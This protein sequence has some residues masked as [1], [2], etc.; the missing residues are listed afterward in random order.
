MWVI[1][2]LEVLLN[3]GLNQLLG[4]CL[5]LTNHG[6][7]PV[8]FQRI[9]GSTFG[10]LLLPGHKKSSW[11]CGERWFILLHLHHH[12]D[13]LIF[14]EG[15]FPPS[16]FLAF[17]TPQMLLFFIAFRQMPA[18][19]SSHRKTAPASKTLEKRLTGLGLMVELDA[20]A[21]F[22]IELKT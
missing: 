9:S 13:F 1:M 21:I 12:I 4:S 22:G 10:L 15:V 2:S 17:A 18:Q 11:I 20:S 8:A 19:G 16:L 3:H 6:S 5:C 7:P 14:R